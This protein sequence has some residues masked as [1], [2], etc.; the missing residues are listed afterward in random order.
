MSDTLNDSTAIEQPAITATK[1][2]KEASS[3]NGSRTGTGIIIIL[4]LCA[5][6]FIGGRWWLKSQTHIATD[7]AFIEA[8]LHSVAA[9]VP[10]TVTKV[11]VND[12]QQ[13][14]KGALLVELDPA[15]YQVKVAN[16]SA[17][18]DLA[19]NETS[20]I[21]AQMEAAKAAVT[22]DRARLEQAELDLK[23][24]E[25]IYAKEV[26]PREHLEKLQTAHKV[27][28]AKLQETEG[29][30]KRALALLGLIG[31]GAKDA[32]AAQKSA[33]LQ[34]ARL[35]LSYTKIFAPADGVITKKSVEIGNIV[36]AGQPLMAL[37]PVNDV[38]VTANYKERQ[39]THVR[40]G[41][42]VE[43]TVD[44]YPGT[45]F[46]GT[47]ESIMAGTGAA[48]SLLPPENATGNYVKVV[49]RIPVK[50]RITP[51]GKQDLS[52]RVGMS[53]EPTII[54]DRKTSDIIRGLNPFK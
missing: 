6:A 9:R 30:V 22:S 37:V 27:A 7:D 5:T 49:Q 33:D 16:N 45:I 42:P 28:A 13:V 26:I 25:A 46:H 11:L 47:V 3:A 15:D 31:N 48:F 41:Q 29:S 36:Q 20:S 1:E 23:R 2:T 21:Y 39:L 53:V 50:I 34:A 44:A 8:T 35:N 19:R 18:L 32:Q 12:N 10:G 24:G 4:L 40:P 51:D 54:I 17:Q 52:L 38:W 14:K 43:F